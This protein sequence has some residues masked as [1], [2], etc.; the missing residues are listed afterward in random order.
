MVVVKTVEHVSVKGKKLF[1]LNVMRSDGKGEDVFMNI[2]EGTYNGIK[3]LE[4]FDGVHVGTKNLVEPILGN[5]NILK[6]SK[7]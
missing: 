7:K 3:A 4:D 6:N 5:V 2:G 1:Y